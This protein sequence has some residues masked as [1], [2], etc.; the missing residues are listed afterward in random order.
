MVQAI[1][2]AAA[3]GF[4]QCQGHPSRPL[5]GRRRPCGGTEL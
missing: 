1:P 2:G 4:G 5:P 3:D